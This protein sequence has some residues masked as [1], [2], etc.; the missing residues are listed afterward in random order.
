MSDG[1]TLF[2][3]GTGRAGKSLGLMVLGTMVAEATARAVV[4]AVRQAQSLRIG[5][6][7]WPALR[8]LGRTA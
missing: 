7:Y 5:K 8:D 1:D 6:S 3:L 4:Q 2:M